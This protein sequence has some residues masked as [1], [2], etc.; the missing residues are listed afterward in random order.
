V[1][2]EVFLPDSGR[3]EVK[4][5]YRPSARALNGLGDSVAAQVYWSSFDPDTIAVL[6]STTGVSLANLVGT[7][8]LQARVGALRSNP[9]NVAVLAKLDSLAADG[10]TRDRVTLLPDSTGKV[11]SSS[12]AL[13]V[14]ALATG[15]VPA[16]RRVVYAAAIF[17]ASGPAVTFVPNDSVLT[18][19]TG[20]A[21]AR[22]RL[23]AGLVPDSV[24]V[25]VTMQ[26]P[27][28][29]TIPGSPVTFVVEFGP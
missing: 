8:Q 22:L 9:Q 4:D 13:Q 26:R 3:V 11:D 7:G 5:T 25:R 29:D 15:G 10:A 28:G 23:L 6:D 24:I 18:N 2:I 19:A 14:Q 17:P 1:A 16:N 21:T 12:T 27:N 20:V